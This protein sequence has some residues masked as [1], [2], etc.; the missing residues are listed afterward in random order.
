MVHHVGDNSRKVDS[1]K[2]RW[3]V[4]YSLAGEPKNETGD[5]PGFSIA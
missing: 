5:I 2:L 3:R 4:S 1:V